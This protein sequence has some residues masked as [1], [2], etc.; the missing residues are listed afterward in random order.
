MKEE[1]MLAIVSILVSVF[2]S[3][4]YRWQAKNISPC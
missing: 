1:E 4:N 2:R 3:G